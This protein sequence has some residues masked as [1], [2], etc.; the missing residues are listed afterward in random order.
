M[1]RRDQPGW[2]DWTDIY[3]AACEFDNRTVVGYFII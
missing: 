3:P 2:V 1:K